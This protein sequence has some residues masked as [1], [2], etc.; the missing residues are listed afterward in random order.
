MAASRSVANNACRVLAC[1]GLELEHIALFKLQAR[2]GRTRRSTQAS[3][4]LH[5]CIPA[6][7]QTSA[8]CESIIVS[9]R[10]GGKK[11]GR[12]SPRALAAVMLWAG[13]FT[14]HCQASAGMIDDMGR[15]ALWSLHSSGAIVSLSRSQERVGVDGPSYRSGA[16]D[17]MLMLEPGRLAAR[18]NEL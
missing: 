15:C 10:G 13:L 4:R 2:D 16:G 12:L 6:L 18:A 7:R 8:A 5:R 3:K 17:D 9:R 11:V 1:P 14:Y